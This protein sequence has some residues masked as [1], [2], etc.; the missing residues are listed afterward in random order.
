MDFPPAPVIQLSPRGN[1]QISL[2]IPEN[3]L[4]PAPHSR[5]SSFV[6]FLSLNVILPMYILQDDPDGCHFDT[7]QG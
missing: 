7:V 6:S 5:P 2:M 4:H 3:T 1:A